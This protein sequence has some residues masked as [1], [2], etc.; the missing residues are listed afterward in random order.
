MNPKPFECAHDRPFDVVGLGCC[1]VDCLGVVDAY[2]GPDEKV[3]VKEFTRQGGGLSGTAI[4]ALARLGAR[5]RFLAKVG[6]DELGQFVRGSFEREGVDV[7]GLLMVPNMTALF[8]YIVVTPGAGHRNI[9]WTDDNVP[10]LEAEDITREQVTSARCLYV[11]GFHMAA[12]RRAVEWAK[13]DDMLIGI[14]AELS[15][16]DMTHLVEAADVVIASEEFAAHFSG[17]EDFAE[18]APA[19]FDQLRKTSDRKVVVVTAGARGAFCVSADEAFLQPAFKLDVKDTT[20]CGDV[21]HGA[22]IFGVLK[23]WPLTR[24]AEFASAVAALKARHLGGRAGIPSLSEALR[25]IE[26]NKP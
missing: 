13:E 20:G 8:A 24:T 16:R 9:F 2:P 23:H 7:S 19:M 3:R 6:D 10:T 4:V 17:R 15:N 12:A 22:F 21:F 26:R 5:T 14:D 18:S 11:D 25:F 1:A